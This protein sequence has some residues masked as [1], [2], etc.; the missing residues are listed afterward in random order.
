MSSVQAAP[1]T[2]WSSL[3]QSPSWCLHG[4]SSE[5]KS[6]CPTTSPPW[7]HCVGDRVGE[8]VGWALGCDGDIEGA[9]VGD[10]LGIAVGAIV[11]AMHTS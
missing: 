9:C 5:Q 3:S 10:A 6:L 7:S 2:H 11:G 1:S 8:V 4:H